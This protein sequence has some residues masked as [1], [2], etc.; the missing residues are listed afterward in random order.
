MIDVSKI[1]DLLSHALIGNSIHF[2]DQVGSTNVHAA[3]LARAG[4]PEG[5]VVIADSQTAGKGRLNRS[6]QS[7]PGRNLYASIVLRPEV[8]LAESARITL[9]TGV[10]V[11]ETVQEYCP[12]VVHVKW[13]NDVQVRGRKICGI[14]A[15]MQARAGRPEFIVIGI[16]VNINVQKAEFR[17]ELR[18]IATSLREETGREIDRT[19]FIIRQLGKFEC[20]YRIFLSG[21]FETIRRRWLQLAELIGKRV[22]IRCGEQI[23]SGKV[24]GMDERGALLLL[25][26]NDRIRE[27]LAGDVSLREAH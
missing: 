18:D 14:L 20:W 11:A 19:D 23:E 25:D 13:P 24:L 7:P 12:G 2:L 8:A 16:G 27:V 22:E 4:A 1:S 3:E 26:D 21:D 5:T 6:W 15:E 17:E 9:T 10:A